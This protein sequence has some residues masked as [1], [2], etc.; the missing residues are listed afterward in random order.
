MGS[1]LPW[2]RVALRSGAVD[3]ND[4]EA[5]DS[6]EPGEFGT[7]DSGGAYEVTDARESTQWHHGP[8]IRHTGSRSASQTQSQAPER[9]RLHPHCQTP[10]SRSVYGILRRSGVT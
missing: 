6:W 7:V 4:C 9:C 1:V 8:T 3:L 2:A 10:L 5:I